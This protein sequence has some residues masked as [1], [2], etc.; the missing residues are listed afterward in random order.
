MVKEKEKNIN[1]KLFSHYFNYSSPSNILSRLS[2]AR[3]EI[4]KNQVNSINETLKIKNIVKNVPKNDPLQTEENK[5][6]IDIVERILELN[7]KNQLGL[8][9]RMLT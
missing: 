9:L 6:I 7:S 4:N 2:E 3:S 5:K 1:N 8:G